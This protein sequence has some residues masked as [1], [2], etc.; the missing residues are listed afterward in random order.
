[1]K[2]HKECPPPPSGKTSF[3]TGK[4]LPP[5]PPPMRGKP[6]G[7]DVSGVMLIIIFAMAVGIACGWQ[8]HGGV[9]S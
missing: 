5:D 9:C 2:S 8:M 7:S 3:T 6:K 1:M 4:S